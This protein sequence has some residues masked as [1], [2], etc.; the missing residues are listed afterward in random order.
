MSDENTH[1]V[2]MDENV[3]SP[4]HSLDGVLFN[5]TV[6]N[7]TVPEQKCDSNKS[8]QPITNVSKPTEDDR[9]VVFSV[10]NRH[11]ELTVSLETG[12]VI[13]T[14]SKKR[15]RRKAKRNA[16]KS[17]Q[18][19]VKATDDGSSTPTKRGHESGGTPPSANQPSKVKAGNKQQINSSQLVAQSQNLPTVGKDNRFYRNQMLIQ[20]KMLVNKFHRRL[21]NQS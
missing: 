12:S 11:N 20:M 4:S 10:G 8:A 5:E 14:G 17:T 18:N 2:K 16:A 3:R 15:K 21:K 9:N 6:N 7:P 19:R 1:S 13:A